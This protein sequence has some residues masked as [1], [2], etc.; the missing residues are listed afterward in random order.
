MPNF[1][2]NVKS[3]LSK[4]GIKGFSKEDYLD[5]AIK[6]NVDDPDNATTDDIR[7]GVEYFSS[8]WNSRIAV[9]EMSVNVLTT[10]DDAEDCDLDSLSTKTNDASISVI[11]SQSEIVAAS[12]Q[13][14]G[15]VLSESDIEL[16]AVELTKSSDE[17]V[18][19]LSEV[20]RAIVMFVEH[21]YK[22]NKRNIAE[23]MNDVRDVVRET[24]RDLSIDLSEGLNG[25]SV[26]VAMADSDF[27]STVE[28]C[29]K[30][31]SV[32]F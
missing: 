21:R 10:A 14:M 19:S 28:R 8:K 9:T 6:L 26:D 17:V 16:I 20:K 25:I 18:D 11:G 1:Y 29:L 2:E 22:Q 32:P 12:S 4:K 3:R 30:K 13:S 15:V 5:A 24:N 23:M 27:K 31:F 7:N